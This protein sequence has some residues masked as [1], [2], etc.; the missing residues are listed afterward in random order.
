ME[1][2]EF[3]SGS[4]HFSGVL[5]DD[6]LRGFV[7][8]PGAPVVARPLRARGRLARPPRPAFSPSGNRSRN[9]V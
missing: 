3:F 6:G 2:A 9:A 1:F 5:G 8:H 7:K 4:W